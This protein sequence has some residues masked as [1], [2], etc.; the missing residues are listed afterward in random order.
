MS[1]SKRSNT[2]PVCYT[3]PL[4]SLKHWND[5]FFWFDA[6]AIPLYVSLHNNKSLKKDPHPQPTEFNAEVCDFLAT[7]TALFWKF[8][9]SFLCF[10]GISRYYELDE[11]VYPVFLT[12][13]DEGGCSLFASYPTKIRIGEKQIEE[14]QTLLIDSTRGR[15]V[16]LTGV[17]EQGNQNDN[18]QDVDAHVVQDEGVNIVAGEEVKAIRPRKDHG[19]SGDAGASTAGK[20]LAMLQ[21]F[22]DSSTLAAEVSV[23]A[24][25]T[26]P[27]VTSF[28]TSTPERKSGGR[29][30]SISE[31]NLRTQHPAERFIIFS[32]SSHHSSANAVDDEVTSIVRSSVPPP[33]Y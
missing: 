17:N 24:A 14:G 1:F 4:D 12:D 15:V 25:V 18:V 6:F 2:A 20:S 7:H 13:D 8:P 10:V 23:T 31:L 5:S 28:V 26:A 32:D 9:E 29:T 19:T 3:K 27:F 33:P 16:L 22:L 11:N 30:D 21:D